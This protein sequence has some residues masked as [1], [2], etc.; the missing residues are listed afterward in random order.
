MKHDGYRIL[1]LKDALPSPSIRL[2]SI[3][4]AFF[5]CVVPKFLFDLVAEIVLEVIATDAIGFQPS[6]S[7]RNLRP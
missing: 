5:G 7:V 1:P 2:R 6:D 4:A 3:P